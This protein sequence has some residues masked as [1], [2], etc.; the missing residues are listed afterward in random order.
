METARDHS[1]QAN[2]LA[3]EAMQAANVNAV[4]SSEV[5]NFKLKTRV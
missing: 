4:K 3:K 1:S 2:E 5:P